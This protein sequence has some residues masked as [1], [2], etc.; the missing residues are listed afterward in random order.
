MDLGAQPGNIQSNCFLS[1]MG[2]LSLDRMRSHFSRDMVCSRGLGGG[3]ESR[4]VSV[5]SVARLHDTMI[6]L[7]LEQSL[8]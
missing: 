3:A 6:A 5:H 8:D 1:Q 2:K 4:Q 7:S